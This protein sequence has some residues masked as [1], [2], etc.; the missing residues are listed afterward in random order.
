MAPLPA[1]WSVARGRD[2][3]LAENGFTLAAYDAPWTQASLFALDFAV[4]NTK[5]HAAAIRLHDLHHVATGFG[6]DLAGEG[7]ISAWEVRGGL[8]GAGLYVSTIVVSGALMGLLLAPRRTLRAWR[9]AKNARPLWTL[10]VLYE[11]LMSLSVEQLRTLVGTAPHGVVTGR[12]GLHKNAPRKDLEADRL[13]S[14]ATGPA[15]SGCTGTPP[16]APS[17]SPS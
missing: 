15:A 13:Q 7:E 1:D 2:A 4:P 6:T 12:Q 3:Y 5:P 16:R 8:R 14:I 11:E 17:W 9:A 10:G